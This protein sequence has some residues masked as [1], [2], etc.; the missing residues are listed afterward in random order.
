MLALS[1]AREYPFSQVP[2]LEQEETIT[3]QSN[4]HLLDVPAGVQENRELKHWWTKRNMRVYM[5]NLDRIK[6]VKA[7]KVINKV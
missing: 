6:E 4:F 2:Y 7:I 3:D 5:G 1:D